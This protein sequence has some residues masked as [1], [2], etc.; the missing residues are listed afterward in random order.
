MNRRRVILLAAVWTGPSLFFLTLVSIVYFA[1]RIE[2]P[3]RA[4]AAART[5]AMA[6]MRAAL[7]GAPPPP[8]SP[9]LGVGLEDQ[10]P[11]VTVV[12][13]DGL[14]VAR[15][16]GYGATWQAALTAAATELA[17]AKFMQRDADTRARARI[18][19]DAVVGRGPF[20]GEHVVFDTF[21]V[22]GVTNLFAINPGLE[23]IGASVDGKE[24]VLVP[25]DLI[26]APEKPL[27]KVRP[28]KVAQDVTMGVDLKKIDGML[29]RLAGAKPQTK[30]T[31]HFRLRVDSFAERALADR[32]QAP[33]SLYRDMPARPPLSSK[34]LREAA[35]EGG[36]YL[37]AHLGPNGRYVYN[38]NLNT[39]VTT[40]P[41][42]PG[43]Y[44][45]PRHAG[46]T[47]FMAELYRLTKEEWLREPI[48]RAFNHLQD[49]VDESGCHGTTPSGE[50]FSCVADRGAATAD[51]GST[52]LG[53]VAL[54]EYQRATNDTR[55]LDLATR[56]TTW[57]LFMQRPDGTFRYYMNIKTKV[58]DEEKWAMYY[59]GEAALAFARMGVVTGDPKYGEA[60]GRAIDR[61]VTAYDFFLGGFFYGEEHWTCISAEAAYPAVK[62]DKYR[63]FCNGYGA[64]LRQQQ[65]E[66]GDYPDE[67][68]LSGAYNQPPTPFVMPFNTPAG[69]R[70]EAMISAYLLG[71]H[72]GKPEPE[73]RAQ[74]MAA[75]HYTLGQMITPEGDISSAGSLRVHGAMP[76]SPIDRVVRIDYVQHVCSAM[77]RA[78][79]MMDEGK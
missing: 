51:L 67:D 12:Y 29:V 69:S 62:R 30:P 32:A 72:H 15:A 59:A 53:V 60:A 36:R 13:L 75:L 39:G 63:T 6:V 25:H 26:A 16:V 64:F 65:A 17:K 18:R 19:I 7:T 57:L 71:H 22:G 41:M 5:D 42:R 27:Q 48:E 31:G 44:S 28:F 52:A 33:V 14:E 20:P 61:L 66:V 70:T 8:A 54:A 10:G 78:A 74:I 76:G 68:D 4:D 47:Y 2:V 58:V 40:D 34:A 11:I 73:I 50:P 23:G 56:L 79:A 3:A 38:H 77:I 45:I 43:E 37:V 9:R 24:V 49:L 1:F 55:Y 21:A 35:L 46:T